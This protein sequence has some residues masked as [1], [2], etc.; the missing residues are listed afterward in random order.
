ME[1]ET[2]HVLTHL[3]I[4]RNQHHHMSP[5]SWNP[6]AVRAGKQNAWNTE[7]S[8]RMGV[9]CTTKDHLRRNNVECAGKSGGR[10]GVSPLL[11]AALRG[12]EPAYSCWS[13][14]SQSLSASAIGPFEADDQDATWTIAR[15]GR[16][17]DDG[18]KFGGV[19]L[20][21][22]I[23]SMVISLCRGIP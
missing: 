20:C 9:D 18:V 4:E 21:K 15:T 8:T 5:R 23:F 10:T 13:L 14:Q 11:Q 19:G 7:N 22:E 16:A 2:R 6:T 17:S 3:Y 12:G 1:A